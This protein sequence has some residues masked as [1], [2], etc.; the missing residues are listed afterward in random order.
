MSLVPPGGGDNPS[1]RRALS[2]LLEPR[3]P[4]CTL[5]CDYCNAILEDRFKR[6][7][8]RIRGPS[9]LSSSP[10]QSLTGESPWPTADDDRPDFSALKENIQRINNGEIRCECVDSWDSVLCPTRS[11]CNTGRLEELLEEV[12]NYAANLEALVDERTSAYLEEKQ[13][14]EELLYQLLP[15]SVASHLVLGLP[16]LAEYYDSVTIY[17]S[18]IIGFTQLCATSTPLEVVD[19][20][21]DLYT[22]FDSII[23]NFDVYKVETIG[24]AYMVVSGLPQRNGDRHAVEI[25]S[26]SLALLAA[27]RVKTVLHRPEEPL[28]LRIGMH[29]GPCV[30]GVVGLKMPRYCLFGDTVNTASRME[31]HSDALRIHVSSTTKELLDVYDMFILELRGEIEVKGKGPMTTYWLLGEKP[32]AKNNRHSGDKDGPRPSTSFAG[33]NNANPSITFQ[34]PDSPAGHSLAQNGHTNEINYQIDGDD[35]DLQSQGACALPS[36]STQRANTSDDIVYP[37][38]Y[39]MSFQ[40]NPVYVTTPK[41]SVELQN[42][43]TRI[44]REMNTCMSIDFVNSSN[45]VADDKSKEEVKQNLPPEDA[46]LETSY[47]MDYDRECPNNE[48]ENLVNPSYGTASVISKG[49]VRATVLMF[50][51]RWQNDDNSKKPN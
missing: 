39:E 19:M 16:V 40:N 33:D 10:R 23:E 5:T 46:R 7:D 38:E 15:K 22:C 36:Y 47:E 2:P 44:Q 20:L 35:D 18:D 50:N 6:G 26:M 12:E 51:R 34:G 28:L 17:F 43:R 42:E 21:N 11:H 1:P 27:V 48:N 14:C 9:P 30:A 13:R 25:A 3:R 24:D 29:T 32:V 41:L 31:A 37:Q 4:I 49:K 45:H 8:G